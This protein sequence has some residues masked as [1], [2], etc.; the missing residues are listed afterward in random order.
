MLP[1]VRQTFVTLLKKATFCGEELFSLIASGC[2]AVHLSKPIDGEDNNQ[3]ASQLPQGEIGNQEI[4]MGHSDITQM[5]QTLAVQ[6]P[7]EKIEGLQAWRQELDWLSCF[8]RSTRLLMAVIEPQTFRLRYA[9]EAFCRLTGIEAPILA[10]EPTGADSTHKGIR[11]QELFP[12]ISEATAERLYRRHLLHIVLRDL[13]RIDLRELRLLDE[14]LTISLHSPLYREPRYIE[15]WL[16]SDQLQVSRIDPKIDEFAD[17]KLHQLSAAERK[18]EHLDVICVVASQLSVLEERLRLDNYRIEGWLLLEGFDVTGQETM[19]RLTQLLIQRESILR[20][21]KFVQVNRRLRALFRAQNTLILSSEREQ[22]QL[23]FGNNSGDLRPVVFSMQ[24]LNGSHFLRAAKANQVWNVPDLSLDCQTDCE[25]MLLEKGVRSMLLIPL[26]V[27]TVEG[28]SVTGQLAGL[29]GL[30]SERPHNFTGVDCKHAEALI[31]AFIAA[32]RQAIQQ[33]VTTLHNI[34]PSVEW[35]FLQEAE[36]RSWGLPPEPIVFTDVY[37]LYGISD[38]RGS[39]EERNRAIQA[40]LLE[41]F[42]LAIAVVEAVC[43]SQ[44]TA[45]GEQQRLDLLEYYQK[46]QEQVTVDAEVTAIQYLKQN[47]EIYFDYFSECSPEA[48][49]AVE[50]YRKSCNNEH[51]CVYIAR[52]HYDKTIEKINTLLR[53]TWERW[54][55]RMQKITSHYCDIESTDGIDHMI[56]AG[57]SIDPKFTLFHLH[58]LR[59]EQLRAVCD[60]ART[61]FRIQQEYGTQLQVT[62]L[63]L[64]QDSTVDIFHDEQTDKLFDVRG[65]RDTRYEIVKKRIDKAVDAQTQTRITQPGMLTI[66]YSTDAEWNEYQEYLRYLIREGWVDSEIECGMVEQLQGVSGL[67]FA[68]VRVLPAPESSANIQVKEENTRA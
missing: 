25:R 1:A 31:P 43:Q 19:R 54:Q 51:G 13:Y 65:T 28:K 21:D 32:L 40:D 20:P 5:L 42:R 60:C 63:V 62:H 14:P 52:A 58:S 15:F 4:E 27:K 61:A 24:A 49:A 16:D 9:N 29:V 35:R 34:H 10:G 39:S 45:F 11:L 12:D 66:V 46:L 37:P 33:R 3:G 36:R 2:R 23:F 67:R 38:I 7:S 59:Y 30:T 55:V 50:T 68:R 17:L 64:V 26:V 6:V 48:L 41:Q 18:P 53:E 44:E 57:A 47:I 56:Y 22:A 8:Q